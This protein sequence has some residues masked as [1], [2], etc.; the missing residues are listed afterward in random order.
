VGLFGGYIFDGSTWQEFDP[1]SPVPGIAAPWL[2]VVVYDSDIAMIRYEPARPG[3][4]TAYLGYTPRAYFGDESAS[5]PVDVQR[6]AAG[7]AAR[8]ALRRG[9]GGP[10]ELRK[11]IASFLAD[12]AGR[13][14]RAGGN[15]ADA[16]GLD[17][18]VFVEDKVSRFLEAIG[19]P[20]PAD[21]AG[22]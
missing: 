2:S 22:D 9:T 10:A 1:D 12:D 16:D 19:I 7:L 3:S 18:G 21:L 8:L 5:A 11:L 17:D 20:A 4:G 14:R 13:A 6:E 15:L